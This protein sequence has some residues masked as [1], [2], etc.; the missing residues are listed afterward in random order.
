MIF[1][2]YTAFT[3][4]DNKLGFLFTIKP[5]NDENKISD[6]TLTE[7]QKKYNIFVPL[8]EN[9]GEFTYSKLFV[10]DTEKDKYYLQN[11]KIST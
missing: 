4:C 9:K 5:L 7:N 10:L 8:V 2:R 6:I 1:Q 3:N 11:L